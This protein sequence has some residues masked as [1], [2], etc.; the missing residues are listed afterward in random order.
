MDSNKKI[1]V[2]SQTRGSI[3]VRCQEANFQ[4]RWPKKGASILIPFGTLEQLMFD[5][6]FENMVR[7][8]VLY[9]DDMDAKIELGLEPAG[10]TK[11]QNIIILSDDEM[12]ACMVTMNFNDFKEKV[13]SLNREQ[14]LN[15]CDY[16]IDNH[17]AN[18][19]KTQYLKQITGKD[20]YKAIQLNEQAKEE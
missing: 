7:T 10:A 13:N 2:I 3:G 15:L 5:Q 11:P 6:G 19:E 17:L 18:Y 8:G 4:H 12:R 16:A 9:I 1:K 20:I 14:L